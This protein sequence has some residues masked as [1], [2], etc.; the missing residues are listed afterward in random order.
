MALLFANVIFFVYLCSRKMLLI[1]PLGDKKDAKITKK[2][3]KLCL[4]LVVF[5]EL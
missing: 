2:R 1:V 3:T 4:R 5:M